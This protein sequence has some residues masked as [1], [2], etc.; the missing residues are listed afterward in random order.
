[1]TLQPIGRVGD[2][3]SKPTWQKVSVLTIETLPRAIENEDAP[4][5]IWAAVDSPRPLNEF[6]RGLEVVPA[7]TRLGTGE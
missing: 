5:V 1:M 4:H 7:L 2:V 3:V 6:E